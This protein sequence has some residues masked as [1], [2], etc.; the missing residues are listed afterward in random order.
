MEP[1]EASEAGISRASS[2]AISMINADVWAS[3]SP[4]QQAGVRAAVDHL[5]G[6]LARER[7]RR[8]VVCIDSEQQVFDAESR[9]SGL[10]ARL[11]SLQ[12]EAEAATARAA[13]L[14]QQLAGAETVRREA[15]EAR[16]ACSAAV[17]RAESL[18]AEL[19]DV[20]RR[21]DDAEAAKDAAVGK[22]EELERERLTLALQLDEKS[23]LADCQTGQ[24]ERL[25]TER[26]HL[27][28]RVHLLES[29]LAE[30]EQ[31]NQQQPG[32]AASSTAAGP[33][34]SAAATAANEEL[35]ASLRAK[36][37]NAE[38]RAADLQARLDAAAS[39][40][41]SD[42]EERQQLEESYQRQL[43][44]ER[45]AAELCKTSAEEQSA[46]CAELSSAAEGMRARLS[47]FGRERESIER[48]FSAQLSEAASR[49]SELE[50]T[51]NQLRAQLDEAR[52]EV[53]RLRAGIGALSEAEIERLAPAA[54]ATSRMLKRGKTLTQ[55]YAEHVEVQGQLSAAR[56][57]A[58]KANLAVAHILEEV[59]AKV[60][61]IRRRQEEC[62]RV[63]LSAVQL[64]KRLDE[65]VAQMCD[66]KRTN[67]ELERKAA[68]FERENARLKARAGDLGEQVASLLAKIESSGGRPLAES[69]S[70][71][72]EA[73]QPEAGKKPADSQQQAAL[74]LSALSEQPQSTQE[75]ITSSLLT[76]ADIRQL[77]QRNIS[78]VEASRELAARLEVLERERSD[79]SELRVK[80]ESATSEL[81]LARSAEKQHRDLLKVASQQRDM[82][83]LLLESARN[84]SADPAAAA[85]SVPMETD[86]QQQQQQPQTTAAS[87][88]LAT[89]G[90]ASDALSSAHAELSKLRTELS[91]RDR[92]RATELNSARAQLLEAQRASA[93]L[94]SKLETA[95]RRAELGEAGCA[96][97]RRE[98]DIL[99][100][101]NEKYTGMLAKHEQE[102]VRLQSQL[103][104][105]GQSV[106]RL[107][108][109]L[110]LAKQQAKA[111][112]AS[113]SR[114]TVECE[115]LRQDRLRQ[116]LLMTSL[117]A[118]QVN[119]EKRDQEVRQ[120]A[121]ARIS[122]AAERTT[123]LERRLAEAESA[124]AAER[125][126]AE[127]A[128][129]SAARQLAESAERLAAAVSR[130]KAAEERAAALVASSSGQQQSAVEQSEAADKA[131][132]SQPEDNDQEKSSAIAAYKEELAE[133]RERLKAMERDC[134]LL[135][136]QAEN[137]RAMAEGA[138]ARLTQ[139]AE[140][141]Q[142]AVGDLER[143][144][145][146]LV[147]DR[148]K[149]TEEAHAM[150]ADLRKQLHD[151]QQELQAA[152]ERRDAAVSAED[153]AKARATAEAA[154]AAEA[155]DKYQQELLLHAADAKAMQAIRAQLAEAEKTCAEAR[156][157]TRK[158]RADYEKRIAALTA[159]AQR[160]RAS[161]TE[162]ETRLTQ[163]AAEFSDVRRRLLAAE[164]AGGA[165]AGKTGG[166]RRDSL[167]LEDRARQVAE[168]QAEAAR[169][170]AC[171]LSRQL[172][173]TRAALDE[174]RSALAA[175]AAV[176]SR[177]LAD[178]DERAELVRAR[179]Q[180]N[181]LTESNRLLRQ[182]EARWRARTGELS[183]RAD[184]LAAQLA[185]LRAQL[186][187]AATQQAEAEESARLLTEERNRWRDRC[188]ELL[189][190][191]ERM[192]ADQY[193]QACSE[194][195]ALQTQVESLKEE[196]DALNSDIA[197][198][199]NQLEETSEKYE[200]LTEESKAT[201]D[202]LA[203]VTS[204]RDDIDQVL[205]QKVKELEEL[206]ADRDRLART[207]EEQRERYKRVQEV[208][209]KYK[210]E[211]VE[212]RSGRDGG[213]SELAKLNQKRPR[214]EA[215]EGGDDAP[216]SAPSEAE[217]EQAAEAA[218][219]AEDAQLQPE[220]EVDQPEVAA[221]LNLE[222]FVGMMSEE[223]GA[224]EAERLGEELADE[225]EAAAEDF[226]EVVHDEDENAA[227]R[228]EP[229][230]EHGGQD[231]V[232]V[233]DDEEDDVDNDKEQPHEEAQEADD[234]AGEEAVPED[235][236]A[237]SA[238]ADETSQ[239]DAGGEEFDGAGD[240]GTG[241]YGGGAEDH[242]GRT[243]SASAA[244]GELTITSADAR[245]GWD[246]DCAGRCRGRCRV[247]SACTAPRLGPADDAADHGRHSRRHRQRGGSRR[248]CRGPRRRAAAAR[249]RSWSKRKPTDDSTKAAAMIWR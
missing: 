249:L 57:E 10:S 98:I 16:S 75:V 5:S 82:Y 152:V 56:L 225:P 92:Q 95:Q 42:R 36:L 214:Q 121:E 49:Q 182:D 177:Q 238:N 40:S 9:T 144:R 38:S 199:N 189:E 59:Q 53:D 91:S 206:A 20:Q 68:F 191:T 133:L 139:Q 168:Y 221:E 137:Y 26:Q 164:E 156:E 247:C 136:G 219:L 169:A 22:L 39:R 124:L 170:E 44:A 72:A 141:H 234:E 21:L 129:A 15:D 224:D 41:E 237:G 201:Q 94:S 132:S 27:E 76:F 119:L 130:A 131:E 178:A 23:S 242:E 4:E 125:S 46:R 162:A 200:A 50:A 212:L 64:A 43:L 198:L 244:P 11:A 69:G 186:A 146:T 134:E 87:T 211:A 159:E 174:A 140:E 70:S 183:S 58:D 110:E 216:Q 25:E 193:K 1:T 17:Q 66:L 74:D 24:I 194:R 205:A 245:D 97:Y 188:Q 13:E 65:S 116:G 78:L 8:R 243:D 150:N 207:L 190:K 153:R 30:Q 218:E 232:I 149:Q 7:E 117:Q 142:T 106:T 215:A 147:S 54:A 73:A 229:P 77:Q 210:Q 107:E 161:K 85:A 209:R 220:A 203:S 114:L 48:R 241:E 35:L 213:E 103:I 51:V 204:E 233:L 31:Q 173:S 60:P 126:A 185:P 118:V 179:E 228:A 32:V 172:E 120:A 96:R 99:R 176:P 240:S 71:E 239:C 222:E 165:P 184:E 33:A 2:E 83:K 145:Q 195:D 187:A 180:I 62:R 112:R 29:Q 175:S 3:L 163:L 135:R 143:E 113:E 227:M 55:I 45:A 166:D 93:R 223:A 104:E 230:S 34:E 154:K 88:T 84:S 127:A 80:L 160:L 67:E 197:D 181:L 167:A 100:E 37:D 158:S 111:L 208:A 148:F 196:V 19:A 109:Q 63:R 12:A 236:P 90:V 115:Q 108:A 89:S 101:M 202:R 105:R 231:D 102:A 151:R 86:Q 171:R 157:E 47:E 128:A 226:A 6:E 246:F 14:Q 52:S 248:R 235:E 217:M 61:V 28:E 192:D 81:Q 122:A 155:A 138:E 18:T 123:S 79:A